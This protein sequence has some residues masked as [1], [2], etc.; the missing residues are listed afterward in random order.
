MNKQATTWGDFLGGSALAGSGVFAFGQLINEILRQQTMQKEKKRQSLPENSLVIDIPGQPPLSDKQGEEALPEEFIKRANDFINNTAA[1]MLGLP[2]GYVGTK[3]VYDLWKQKQL[4]NEISRAK[5]KY[6][7][8]LQQAGKT[9][10]DEIS[11]DETP[12]VDSLCASIA[13]TLENNVKEAEVKTAAFK[14]IFKSLSEIPRQYP[15]AAIF[16]TGGLAAL[17]GGYNMLSGKPAVGTG[18][19]L[20]GAA[21]S[22]VWDALKAVA[23]LTALTTGG[24]MIHASRNKANKSEPKLPSAVALN[25]EEPQLGANPQVAVN[26]Q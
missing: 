11:N 19:N 4:E 18:K 12:N 21:A 24:A 15:R 3:A 1:V 10:S 16:G 9:A 26:P 7:A 8:A 2:A 5:A 22:T 25:Y 23:A 20:V 13:D 6:M 17:G 14:D